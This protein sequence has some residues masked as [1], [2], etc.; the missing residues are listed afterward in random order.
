[1]YCWILLFGAIPCQA[2][3]DPKEREALHKYHQEQFAKNPLFQAV[4]DQDEK[5]LKGLFE[6]LLVER[7]LFCVLIAL[8]AGGKFSIH[9]TGPG[10]TPIMLAVLQAY[11]DMVKVL[12][13]NG[14]NPSIANHEGFT[15][16]HAASFRGSPKI[17]EMLL[18]HGVEF[19][20]AHTDGYIP[21]HRACFGAEPGH[22]KVVQAFLE[23]GV[24]P[25][26]RGSNGADCMALSK[27]NRATQ[28]LLA[29]FV[30]KDEL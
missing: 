12:L 8:I 27:A 20:K 19:D 14:A 28:K 30:K 10:M 25:Y 23:H 16:I 29:E 11:T 13:E 18:A 5:K 24:D 3:Q 4:H 22:T 26:I 6:I 2:M 15:P 21:F 17:V 7:E 1:M 9:D